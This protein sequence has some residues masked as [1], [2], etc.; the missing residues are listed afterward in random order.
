MVA[1]LGEF[2][3]PPVFPR[4]PPSLNCNPVVVGCGL[5]H[6]F[7]DPIFNEK[8][9]GVWAAASFC[10]TTL[11]VPANPLDHLETMLTR[12]FLD[13]VIAFS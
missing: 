8:V 5:V 6:Q 9:H 4:S 3:F 2:V 1:S 10:F 11:Q 7:R 13:S 12:K